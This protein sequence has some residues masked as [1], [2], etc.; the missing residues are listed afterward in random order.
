MSNK[1]WQPISMGK[2]IVFL[3]GASF[4]FFLVLKS[5][6]GFV[7]VI[8]HA[9]LLFHEAGHPIFG[10]L[11]GTLALYGGTLG[12][13]TFPMVLV[14]SFWWKREP[15]SCAAASLWFFENWLNIARYMA[16][17]RVLELPLVG[18][19]DHDWEDIFQRWG[20][21]EQDVRIASFVRAIGWIGMAA[22][23]GWV[24]WRW[25]RDRPKIHDTALA[26]E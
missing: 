3:V 14:V 15:L 13:L 10:L 1:D 16:D 22:A 25:Y 5:E 4:F 6:P 23:C 2:L 19:G 20:V 11:G 21:L 18:S 9:N 8:D 17:A 7:F 26:T 12:Q 24:L